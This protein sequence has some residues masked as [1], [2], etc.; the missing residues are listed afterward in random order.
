MKNKTIILAYSGGLDTSFCLKRLS[1]DGFDVHAILVNTGGFDK[2]ELNNIKKQAI[3]LGASKF[4]SIDAKKKFYNKIIKFLIFGNVLKNNSYPLSV[5]SERII[6]AIEIMNYSKKN[7][8]NLDI[9]GANEIAKRSRGTPRIAGRLLSRVRD[10][11]LVN[12]KNNIDKI[13]ADKALSKL[14]IDD[15]GLDLIDSNYLQILAEKYIKEN[16]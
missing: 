4:V 15:H 3:Q 5:S 6:Q 8:I 13:E 11:A 12:E 16:N 2:S 9:D 10:F 7:N 14:N 1:S